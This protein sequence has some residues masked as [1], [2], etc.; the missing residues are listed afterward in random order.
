MEIK[1]FTSKTIKEE[2]AF[3]KFKKK[4]KQ[5]QNKEEGLLRR[6]WIRCSQKKAAGKLPIIIININL[7]HL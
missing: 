3:L 4:I 2:I 7:T 1:S 6:V 5:S